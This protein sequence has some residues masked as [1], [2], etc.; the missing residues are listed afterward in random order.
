LL[1]ERIARRHGW[2]SDGS[3]PSKEGLAGETDYERL[4]SCFDF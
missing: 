3:G 2:E 1:N 4:A